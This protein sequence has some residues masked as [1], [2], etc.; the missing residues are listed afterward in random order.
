MK[1]SMV[2]H[3]GNQTCV[4][5]TETTGLDAH[6]H[7][8][9]QI[10]ILP[11]DSNFL[12]RNDVNPFYIEIKPEYPE[13]ADPKAL[14]V[15]KLSFA[16][17]AQRGFSKDKATDLL[18]G[19]INK[20]KLPYTKYGTRKKIRPL[21]HNYAFD[22]DFIIRWLG[23][24]LYNEWFDY[25]YADTMIAANFLNDKAAMHG[26]NTP[27]PKINLTYIANILNVP[28][29]KAHDSLNDCAVTA[30]VYKKLTMHGLF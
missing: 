30:E 28:N 9:I 6:Y 5:D 21:G 10:C 19:W 2:H 15:N 16:K 22:R 12:P 7:E 24:D 29:H 4:I 14:S 23:I 11:I 1:N 17:I 3:N 8:I 26:E 27:Y 13:R 18:E 20:L 25:H